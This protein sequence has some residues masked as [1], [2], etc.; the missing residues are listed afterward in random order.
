MG[1]GWVRVAGIKEKNDH[2]NLLLFKEEF[3]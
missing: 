1:E 3:S 2:S